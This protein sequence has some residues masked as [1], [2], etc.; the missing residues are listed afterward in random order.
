MNNSS[1]FDPTATS[2][3]GLSPVTGLSIQPDQLSPTTL[4]V[5][6]SHTYIP[7]PTCNLPVDIKFLVEFELTNKDQCM[8]IGTPKRTTLMMIFDTQLTITGLE[9]YSTY[10]VYVTPMIRN[11]N[12][13]VTY[14]SGTTWE[15]GTCLII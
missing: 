2:E 9:P 5:T 15:D 1:S 3:G 11:V 8:E 10:N 7:S 13:P 6:W 14:A 12:G 4:L